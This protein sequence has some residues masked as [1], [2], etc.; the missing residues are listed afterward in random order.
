[1][2]R[3]VTFASG[4]PLCILV[5]F[6]TQLAA[7]DIKFSHRQDPQMA[8]LVYVHCSFPKYCKKQTRVGWNNH[9]SPGPESFS[10]W[11]QKCFD[12]AK[13]ARQSCLVDSVIDRSRHRIC[14]S[15][16]RCVGC[17]TA[18]PLTLVECGVSGA[19]M[20]IKVGDSCICPDPHR[21]GTA[22]RGVV[23]R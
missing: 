3:L 20:Q 17:P 14:R 23:M 10:Y 16:S 6:A 22:L 18:P 19:P 9:G 7:Q 4:I 1:M 21:P 11:R 12:D 2:P 13:A 8:S 5:V 15:Y